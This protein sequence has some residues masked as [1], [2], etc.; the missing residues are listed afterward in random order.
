MSV[1]DDLA[2]KSDLILQ[3]ETLVCERLFGESTGH[4]WF[5]TDR[6]RRMALRLADEDEPSDEPP[7]GIAIAVGSYKP[8]HSLWEL[9]TL[10][11]RV[12]LAAAITTPSFNS[13]SYVQFAPASCVL[14]FFLVL[15]VKYD[16]YSG[17]LV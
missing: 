9:V 14:F 3:T 8:Q 7:P 10:A 5:H 15:Q 11:R 13:A 1:N 12:A 17:Q 4:D 6:V 16:P 2:R